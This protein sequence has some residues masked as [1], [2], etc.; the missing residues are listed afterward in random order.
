M[1]VVGPAVTRDSALDWER[2][3]IETY[4]G[5]PGNLKAA[6]PHPQVV[7][8]S[9]AGVERI[10]DDFRS[11]RQSVAEF[12]IHVMGRMVHIRYSAGR[13]EQGESRGPWR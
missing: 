5:K 9:G 2:D 11:G 4:Q 1:T 3:R 8:A 12:W 10:L 7:P 13:G 6:R